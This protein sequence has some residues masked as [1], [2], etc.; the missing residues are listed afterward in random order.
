[1]IILDHIFRPRDDEVP[2]VAEPEAVQ[3]EGVEPVRDAPQSV[4]RE[5]SAPERRAAVN[6]AYQQPQHDAEDGHGCTLLH[7][8]SHASGEVSV[9]VVSGYEFYLVKSERK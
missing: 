7:V 3:D 8:K 6:I 9:S 4:C 1:M 5:A 2:V